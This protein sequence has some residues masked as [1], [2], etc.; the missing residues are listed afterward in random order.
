MGPTLRTL[1]ALPKADLHSHIDGSVPARE[2]FQI[3]KK[4]RLGLRTREGL[5]LENVSAFMRFVATDGYGSMLDNIVDRF[6]P[7]TGL[8]QTEEAIRDVGVAYVRGQKE[9]GVAYAEGRF[10]PQYHTREGMSLNEVISSMDAG[11]REGAEKY[12]V[13]VGLIAGIGRESSA[14]L[15]EE[16]AKAVSAS[17]S[18]AALD[19]CG[20]ERGH[21][22]DKF[23]KAFETAVASGLKVTVHA[24][25]GAGSL[26]RNLANIEAAV[27]QLK[28]NR[29]G[30]A[31]CLARDGRLVSMVREKSVAIEMNPISNLVLRNIRGLRDLH[32]RK[33]LGEGINV[34]LNSDDPAIWPHGDLS[35]V[36]LSVCRSYRFGM[37]EVD[38]LA[39]NAFKAAFTTDRIRS[40]LIEGY[41]QAR[42]RLG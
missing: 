33:L 19:L 15:G 17:G 26:A 38:A 12:G 7:I 6:Y 41:L 35:E 8:M 42:R 2:L 14:R 40:S 4:H 5:E 3:A 36:Y 39:K 20:P 25:E 29:I 13:K 23:R 10:A 32:I 24:G 30:H 37:K 21:P 11:L 27:T 31:T 22:P 16:V 1:K 34:S 18:V 28:A 9:D